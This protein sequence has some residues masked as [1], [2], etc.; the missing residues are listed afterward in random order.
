M[1]SLHN[2]KQEQKSWKLKQIPQKMTWKCASCMTLSGL[3][4]RRK[5]LQN[6]RKE[7]TKWKG[8]VDKHNTTISNL[9]EDVAKW[10]EMSKA[11]QGQVES[12]Q[13]KNEHFIASHT[14]EKAGLQKQLEAETKSAKEGFG[15]IA[16]VGKQRK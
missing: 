2:M 14:K 5:R 15:C 4:H 16:I 11:F 12:S 1:I 10:Q 7:V 8:K 9:K 6:L 3:K 13:N